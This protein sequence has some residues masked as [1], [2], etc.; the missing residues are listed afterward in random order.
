MNLADFL[1]MKNGNTVKPDADLF[2]ILLAKKLGGA[3]VITT[4]VGNPLNFLTRKAQKA[5]STKLTMSPIQDLH[6][7][8]NPWPAGG[9]KN[10][11]PYPYYTDDGT[12]GGVSFS[13]DSDGKIMASG[14]TNESGN[15]YLIRFGT[16]KAGTYTLS[17]KG[18]HSGL[19]LRFY[20]RTNEQTLIDIQPSTSDS[21]A[22]ITTTSDLS[23][24]LFFNIPT[25]DIAVNISAYVQLE[26]GSSPSAYAPYSNVCPISGRTSVSLY[27]CKKNQIEQSDLKQGYFFQDGSISSIQTLKV[28]FYCEKYIPVVDSKFTVGYGD[29]REGEDRYLSVAWYDANKNFLSLSTNYRD[30]VHAFDAPNNAAFARPAMG[31]NFHGKQYCYGGN[32]TFSGYEEYTETNEITV[33]FPALGKNLVN[34]Q[35]VSGITTQT[36]IAENLT[37]SAGTYTLSAYCSNSGSNEVGLRLL[38]QTGST[39]I[40]TTTTTGSSSPSLVKGTFTLSEDTIC[41]LVVRGSAGGYNAAVT[42][43]QIESG[44]SETTFE[45]YTTTCYGGTLNLETGVLTVDKK[46]VKISDLS[47]SRSNNG[48]NWPHYL[49]YAN[50]SDRKRASTGICDVYKFITSIEA[51]VLDDCFILPSW[52]TYMY[53]R[54]DSIDNVADFMTNRGDYHIV[55]ELETPT[56]IQL[57]PNEVQLIKGVNNLWT[58]GDEIELT[59]L[60]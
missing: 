8:D 54:D 20:D 10:Q 47:I 4:L 22:T 50:L 53:I 52:N 17:I 42:K 14:T 23:V 25:S 39:T 59:Y 31:T 6:G 37:F 27:G 43:V 35:D 28:E 1:L 49:F 36:T 57:T 30:D 3:G 55:Y 7:Y 32:G 24:H 34:V 16:L 21:Y 51:Q 41:R 44:S 19:K 2:D 9:G 33:T 40:V 26:S 29:Y 38:T 15:F 46:G 5:I 11:I 13:T 56:T 12:Y 58:D 18:D 60:A 48:G 45:P